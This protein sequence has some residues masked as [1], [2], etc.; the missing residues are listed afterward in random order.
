VVVENQPPAALT[1]CT[2]MAARAAP[3]GYTLGMSDRLALAVA[4]HLFKSVP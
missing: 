2:G 4:P 3:D 1:I